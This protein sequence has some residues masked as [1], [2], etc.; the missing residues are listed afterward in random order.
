M[1]KDNYA[2]RVMII[3]PHRGAVTGNEARH[4]AL[5]KPTS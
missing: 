1:R 5:G 3:T 2:V 4:T